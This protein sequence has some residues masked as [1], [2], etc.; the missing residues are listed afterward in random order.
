MKNKN[1]KLSDSS[2]IARISSMFLTVALVAVTVLFPVVSRAATIDATLLFNPSSTSVAV[3]ADF[4]L[5]ARINPGS[6]TVQG[7]NGVQLDITFNKTVLQLNSITASSPFSF[8]I[9]PDATTITNAN[10]S[11]T[12]SVPLWIPGSEVTT[13][14]DVATLSFHGQGAGTNSP[15]SFAATANAPVNDGG[16]TLVVATRTG[17]TVT[18]TAADSTPPTFTINDGASAS[19]VKSDT[20]NITVADASGVASQF[21]GFSADNTCNGSDT[22]N[23]AFTSATNFSVAGDHNDYLCVKATDSSASNNVGYQLVGQLHTDNTGPTFTVNDG[24]AVSST[25]TDTIN[26]T[27]SDSGSGVSTRTYGYSADNVCNGSDTIATTFTSGTNFSIAGDHSD[28]LC[29][30]SV[31]VATNTSYQLV[32]QLHTDNTLPTV[33]QTTPPAAVN[34]STTPSVVFNSNEG[35]T[36]TYGGGCT[37]TTTVAT[38]GPNTIA[39]SPLSRGATYSCTIKVTDLAGNQSSTVNITSFAITYN[40]DLNTDKGVNIS[41]LSILAAD[42]GKT[43]WS[44]HVTDINNDGNVNLSD[45]SILATDYGKSF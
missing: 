16:G 3:G 39:L 45:L 1:D 29:L 4:N 12:L 27:V 26:V 9:T 35:G 14:T 31:D 40:G 13:T 34:I 8:A 33:S 25:K 17:A 30:K 10:L 42:Y 37:S 41:D 28:Y 44:G 23:T 11:G 2:K 22:I 32:G 7:V 38:S 24:I 6:N 15:V 18:V 5:V 21:Y 43:S 19:Y 36:I 20:L